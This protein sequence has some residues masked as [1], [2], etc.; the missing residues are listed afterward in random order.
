MQSERE[1]KSSSKD[2]GQT[3]EGAIKAAETV[4]KDLMVLRKRRKGNQVGGI[5]MINAQR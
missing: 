2:H 4:V 5:I 1:R 3:Q